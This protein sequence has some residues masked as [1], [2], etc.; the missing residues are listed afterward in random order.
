MTSEQE[1][2]ANYAHE[3]TSLDRKQQEDERRKADDS[4]TSR[5]KALNGNALPAFHGTIQD[6]EEAART[7]RK[8]KGKML[9]ELNRLG[10]EQE[11]AKKRKAREKAARKAGDQRGSGGSSFAG[12]DESSQL[13]QDLLLA[14]HEADL[15]RKTHGKLVMGKLEA[16]QKREHV[17]LEEV[18]RVR[19]L[20]L[21]KLSYIR[22]NEIVAAAV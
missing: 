1:E 14:K 5:R 17:V 22:A 19:G 18:A 11:K 12:V 20:L 15:K 7:V 2:M 3:F 10:R 6:A 16:L 13:R 9:G 4:I 21:K 8:E